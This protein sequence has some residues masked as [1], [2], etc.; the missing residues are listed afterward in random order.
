[1]K[2]CPFCAEE[3]QDDAIK[4]KH[5][6]E[7]LIEGFSPSL[8]RDNTPFYLKTS[9]I[10]ATFFVAG[11]LAIPL[12]W[13]RPHTS[14][15]WKIGLTIVILIISWFFYKALMVSVENLQQYYE[16]INGL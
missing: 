16:F 10:V 7:F 8:K 9:F 12:I 11:P 1:M 4:C 13:M 2:K 5:C 3:I 14:K 6:G 15:A